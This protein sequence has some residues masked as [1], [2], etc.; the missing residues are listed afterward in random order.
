MEQDTMAA[1]P[2]TFVLVHG[3]WHGGW[4]WNRVTPLLRAAG[5][6]VWA[7]TL[8]GLADR[9]HLLTPEIGLESHIRDISGLLDYEELERVV[10]VGHSYAGMVITG[11]AAAAPEQ[12][13]HLVYLD[14]F[15]PEAGDSLSGLLSPAREYYYRQQAVTRGQGWRVPPPPVEA[16][17]VTEIADVSLLAEKLT[18]QPLRSFDEPLSQ[19]A[20]A[21]IARTYVHCTE[22]PIAPSFAPFAARAQDHAAWGYHELATGHDAM[23]TAP[24]ALADLLLGL[25]TGSV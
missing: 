1:D 9:A 22:G 24:R 7:P 17:G 3:G 14:A 8:S 23:I 4:C 6:G 16:L 21:G 25:T 15:V 2:A 19:S 5:H 20:P 11:A 18:D 10:L 13:G 12:V